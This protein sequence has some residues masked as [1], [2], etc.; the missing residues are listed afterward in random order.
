M[1]PAVLAA[2]DQGRL[3]CKQC[4]CDPQLVQPCASQLGPGHGTAGMRLIGIMDKPAV[5]A[6]GTISFNSSANTELYG[7][8]ATAD[9]LLDTP[10]DGSTGAAGARLVSRQAGSCCTLLRSF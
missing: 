4:V 10:A 8:E 6:G 9:T 7:P 3:S 1:L 2:Q 5:L